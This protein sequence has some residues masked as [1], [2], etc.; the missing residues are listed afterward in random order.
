M[1]LKH[2]SRVAVL[3][4]LT[5]A[6]VVF[7]GTKFKTSYKAPGAAQVSFAGKKV[8]ALVISKDEHLRV[9]GEEGLARELGA[10]GLTAVPAYRIVPKEELLDVGKAKGWFERAGVEGV[11]ALRPVSAGKELTYV[12]SVWTGANYGSFWGYYPYGWASPYDPGYIREDMVVV[13]ETLIFSVKGDAPLL[14]AGVS[15]STNPKNAA[16]LL[17]DLVKAAAKELRKQGLA[18]ASAGTK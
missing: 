7:A 14:W 17:A 12:P 13:I 8:A 5:G 9:S 18:Q 3:L 6:T 10:R 4:V 16:K 1:H 15:E 2:P 11:V